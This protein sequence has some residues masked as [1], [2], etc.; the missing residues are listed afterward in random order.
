MSVAT[1][2]PRWRAALLLGL[3]LVACQPLGHPFGDDRPSADLLR[4]PD[5]AS[6]AVAPI[7]GE[8]RATAAALARAMAKALQD[9]D[10]PASDRT[11]SLGSYILTG[12]IS[13]SPKA[14]DGTTELVVYW[15]LRD[16]AGHT[17][18]QRT[19]RL[20]AKTAKWSSGDVEA[21][22]QLAAAGAPVLAEAMAEKRPAAAAAA[23]APFVGGAP[24][25]AAPPAPKPAAPGG[26][27]R[28]A[29]RN[30]EGATGDGDKAL[31]SA[32]AAVLRTKDLDIVTDAGAKAD[33]YLQCDVAASPPK[34]GKQHIKIVW[35]VRR[36]DGSEIG[37]VGQ[38]NDVPAGLLSGPWGDVA[39]TVAMAAGDGIVALVERGAPAPGHS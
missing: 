28:L 23:P 32:I 7:E 14:K 39:Y 11:A 25:P 30:A 3:C 2:R 13:Q 22:T 20:R 5:T 4:V 10:V 1:R 37:T 24:A 9:R 12:R 16:R 35:R 15:R 8:P 17:I 38:E 34:A 21:V 6:V 26:R 27:I 29:V 31:A 19:D 33:L 18:A 36:P